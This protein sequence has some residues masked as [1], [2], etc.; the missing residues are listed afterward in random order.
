MLRA[1]TIP[2]ILSLLKLWILARCLHS[3]TP[4][5]ILSLLNRKFLSCFCFLP[6]AFCL[7]PFAFCGRGLNLGET[8]HL[9]KCHLVLRRTRKAYFVLGRRRCKKCQFCRSIQKFAF[10]SQMKMLPQSFEIFPSIALAVG[11]F[12]IK[13]NIGTENVAIK[14]WSHNIENYFW[15]NNWLGELNVKEPRE[16]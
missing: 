14:N 9:R 11:K 8:W 6:F 12:C 5:F 2:F 10:K 4:L 16:R 1:C 3:V 15:R 13:N 7:L